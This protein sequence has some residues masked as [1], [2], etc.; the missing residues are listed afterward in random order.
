MERSRV[1]VNDFLGSEYHENK[2]RI[3]AKLLENLL[4]LKGANN[5]P[6]NLE[7]A[8]D[9]EQLI[10]TMYNNSEAGKQER[11]DKRENYGRMSEAA[12]INAMDRFMGSSKKDT[13]YSTI[14][15]G[16]VDDISKSGSSFRADVLDTASAFGNEVISSFSRLN[17]FWANKIKS[18]SFDKLIQ[19][20][21]EY[22]EYLEAYKAKNGGKT[23]GASMS[24]FINWDK[25]QAAL[26]RENGES[27]ASRVSSARSKIINDPSALKKMGMAGMPFMIAVEGVNKLATAVKQFGE[28]SIKAY[29]KIQSLQTQLSVVYG[30][31]AQS[32]FAFNEIEAFAKKSPF[33]VDVMTQ[34]AILL[35]QSGEASSTLMDTMSRIGDMASG[36]AEKMRSISEVYARILSSTT[37]TARDLRQLANA[38]VPSYA[39]LTKSFEMA[40]EDEMSRRGLS[41]VRQGD[42]RGMLQGGKITA[43]DFKRMIKY[44]TD[45]GG[46]FY[47]AVERGSKTL[48]ARKQNLEDAK[49][50]GKAAVGEFITKWGGTST[51]NSFY[52]KMISLTEGIYSLMEDYYSHKNTVKDF[53]T[54]QRTI[55]LINTIDEYNPDLAKA[56]RE[57]GVFGEADYKS[58]RQKLQS[59]G[60]KLYMEA[61]SSSVDDTILKEYENESNWRLVEIFSPFLPFGILTSVFN[62]LIRGKRKGSYLNFDR[63]ERNLYF[64]AL[65]S[66][67]FDENGNRVLSEEKK[68]E[69]RDATRGYYENYL[70][71]ERAIKFDEWLAGKTNETASVANLRSK[72]KQAYDAGAYGA[73]LLS[74]AQYYRNAEVK[75]RILKEMK[76]ISVTDELGNTSI[77]T[78]LIGDIKAFNQMLTDLAEPLGKLDVSIANLFDSTHKLTETDTLDILRKNLLE[79]FTVFNHDGARGR[80]GIAMND[81][82]EGM[83]EI[84]EKGNDVT[85]EEWSRFITLAEQFSKD[86]N[87]NMNLSE[88]MK[89]YI[90]TA[91]D[92]AFA[93]KAFTTENAET[94]NARQTSLWHEVMGNALGIDSKRIKNWGSVNS[95][96]LYQNNFSQRKSFAS[97]A[98]TLLESGTSLKDISKN[99][100]RTGLGADGTQKFDWQK[101]MENI[102]EMAKRGSISSQQALLSAYQQ[103]IDTL[104][105]LETTGISTI[106]S[107]EHLRTTADALGSAFSLDVEELNDGTVRFKE[108]TIRAAED[109]RSALDK[110]MYQLNNQIIVNQKMQEL[111]GQGASLALKTH[112]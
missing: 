81:D 4:T 95:W 2:A 75:N 10:R 47:G 76:S 50:M 80:F 32:Q 27:W 24:G 87:G 46:T 12:L 59:Q 64:D 93:D 91:F 54:A 97:I 57:A 9:I 44:L 58:A 53:E 22:K 103:Q 18:N 5:E 63:D 15:K 56:L 8:K 102:E 43:E 13:W 23:K 82:I 85:E 70:I 107:W 101:T 105:E 42:L 69:Q 49:E 94:I 62:Q 84:L 26:A 71:Q 79:V 74:D 38:G 39:A 83:K 40:S 21:D 1:S 51:E 66:V 17:Q 28:E 52:G 100:V 96:D 65:K 16:L 78:S 31:D 33:G 112:S 61:Q 111:Q 108:N 77:D 98:K 90:L 37:V 29:E 72:S 110:K 68:K 48:L 73:M 36:N 7:T 19:G 25:D 41:T 45:E 14:S 60:A 109:L 55:E 6:F 20:T 104:N 106:D 30:S 99:M 86:V 34:Q 92:S 35:K 88:S 67:A 11:A 3:D 89:E